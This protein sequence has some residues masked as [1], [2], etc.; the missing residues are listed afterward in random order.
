MM[1]TAQA[2]VLEELVFRACI[3][4]VGLMAGLSRKQL[5]FGTPLYF[6]LGAARLPP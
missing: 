2:P 3:C 5:I 4:A 6:G 1:L